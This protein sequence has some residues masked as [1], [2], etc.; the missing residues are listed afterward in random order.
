MRTEGGGRARLSPTLQEPYRGFSWTHSVASGSKCGVAETLDAHAYIHWACLGDEVLPRH[1]CSFSWGL[2]VGLAV[3]NFS[4]NPQ[5]TLRPKNVSS[6]LTE[7]QPSFSSQNKPYKRNPLFF[8]R[9][10]LLWP[11]MAWSS[12]CS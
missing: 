1:T 11:T 3:G 5:E 12:W 2:P 4:G 6:L 9:Q 10:G 7:S 8:F